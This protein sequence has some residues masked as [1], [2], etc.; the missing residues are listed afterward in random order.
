[1]KMTSVAP[2][3]NYIDSMCPKERYPNYQELKPQIEDA[4]IKILE[5]NSRFEITGISGLF[6][7]KKPI[8]P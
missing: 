7:A 3:I 4:I 1:M 5:K 2:L 8:K 6:I